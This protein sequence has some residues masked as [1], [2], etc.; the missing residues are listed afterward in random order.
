[1][2]LK[3]IPTMPRDSHAITT[4]KYIKFYKTTKESTSSSP[5][6]FHLGHWK[7]ATESIYIATVVS[8]IARIAVQ[9]GYTLTRWKQVI[10]VLLENNQGNPQIHKFITIHILESD[11]N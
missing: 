5:S 10:S 4:A 7:A 8:T 2:R 3:V 11:L 9:N 6:G 1:M